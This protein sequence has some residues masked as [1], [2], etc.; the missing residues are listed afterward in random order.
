MTVRALKD[1][2][3]SVLLSL[4]RFLYVLKPID[5]SADLRQKSGVS[6]ATSGYKIL[7]KVEREATQHFEVFEEQ[8]W[9]VATDESN[10]FVN[11]YS[12]SDFISCARSD[13]PAAKHQHRSSKKV[14]QIKQASFN[15][16]T[17]LLL[18]DK[19]GEIG[20]I[21]INNVSKL[22][23][24]DAIEEECKALNL[25]EGELPAFEEIG[26]YKTL[27][28]HQ[29]T[30]LGMEVSSDSRYIASCD[31]LKKINVVTWPNVFNMQSVCLE[32]SLPIQY[33]CMVG[34]DVVASI[35]EPNPGSKLQDLILSTTLD[36]RVV[37]ASKV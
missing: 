35:S 12:L 6:G 19:M 29:E 37:K 20:F 4:N 33:M 14:T 36:A 8:D 18:A 1:A 5:N 21:N 30:C 17:G 32:H 15:N 28:G 16:I 3:K 7:S 26:A 22:P 2:Q 31:T 13:F 10:K 27:Y 23:S 24:Q 9:L 25:P 11:F 34:S